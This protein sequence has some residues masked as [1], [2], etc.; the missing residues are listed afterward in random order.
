[1]P[2][3]LN[4]YA[5]PAPIAH[6]RAPQPVDPL[7][8]LRVPSLA[9][10]IGSG[11]FAAW[12]GTIFVLESLNRLLNGPMRLKPDDFLF[13]P[14]FFATFPIFIGAWNMRQGTRYRWAYAAAVLATI[15]M[16]TPALCWGIPLGIWA[17]VVLHRRDVREAFARKKVHS[18]AATTLAD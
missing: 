11:L 2:E 9:L 16:L 17:L 5:S 12:G 4:P 3:E 18:N 15:P 13:V 10:L 1:M 7:R 8:P 14:S 6:D